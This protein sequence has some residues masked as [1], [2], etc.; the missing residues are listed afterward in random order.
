MKWLKSKQ[1]EQPTLSLKEQQSKKMAELGARL[2]ASRQERASSLEEMVI[3][4]KIPRRLLEAMEQGKLDDLPEPV[5]IQG[6]IRQYA[7]ALGFN[8]VEF[9]SSFPSGQKAVKLKLTTKKQSISSTSTWRHYTIGLLRPFHLYLLYIFVIVCSVSSLSHAL[10]NNAFSSNS[11]PER[12]TF[13]SPPSANLTPVSNTSNHTKNQES[14]HI[15]VTLKASSWIRVV[16]DG[17]VEFEGVLRKGSQPTWKAQE[18]LTVKTDN[19]GSVL[20][21]VNQQAAQ[22]IGEPGQQKE[23][24]IGSRPTLLIKS[25]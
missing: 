6:L 2:C 21:S 8:G 11:Q 22:Q 23:I 17:K 15:G 7:N 19:G 10:N 9:A 5:Y 13:N 18:E 16:A 4:T 25:R 14:V 1:Q 12:N 3:V 24:R 20:M